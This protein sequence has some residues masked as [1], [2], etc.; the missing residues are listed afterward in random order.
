M[1]KST[2]LLVALSACLTPTDDVPAC[3]D[4]C[5]GQ[6]LEVA[7]DLPEVCSSS[8]VI[9]IPRPVW[10][11]NTSDTFSYGFRFKAPTTPGAPVLVYLPG[12]PGQG[13]MDTRPTSSRR[14]GATSPPTRAASAATGSRRCRPATTLAGSSRPTS[15]QAT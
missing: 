1:M 4:K 6:D 5:D 8:E 3:G 12:G 11:G 14:A 13:S 7:R 15:S 2:L 10:D 9:R